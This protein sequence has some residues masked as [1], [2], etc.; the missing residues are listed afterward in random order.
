MGLE[1]KQKKSAATKQNIPGTFATS[2]TGRS[3][4][5]QRTDQ[6][7]DAILKKYMS[8][9]KSLEERMRDRRTNSI[10]EDRVSN[11]MSFIIVGCLWI[12]GA[13]VLVFAL[14]GVSSSLGLTGRR[15]RGWIVG[16]IYAR[17]WIGPLI[18]LFG[19]YKVV[20]GLMSMFRV[21]D[22]E[23]QEQLPDRF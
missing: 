21:L 15:G 7:N 4:S 10:E 17:Y 5:S 2:T 19:V 16:L 13:V 8:E 20:I 18:A 1:G 14:S 3:K 11:S 6:Q 22:I 23:S 12:L 9:E